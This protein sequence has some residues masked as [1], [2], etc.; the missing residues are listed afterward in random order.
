MTNSNSHLA[1][2]SRAIDILIDNATDELHDRDRDD[3]AAIIAPHLDTLRMIANA[4]HAATCDIDFPDLRD[5][6][7]TLALDAISSHLPCFATTI[8]AIH[9]LCYIDD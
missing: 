3:Y 8:D 7:D 4:A 9:T 2:I 6:L 1:I 5:D